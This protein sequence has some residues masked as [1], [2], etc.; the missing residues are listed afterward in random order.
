MKEDYQQKVW[1]VIASL[2][3][4]AVASGCI[5]E[6]TT[7]SELIRPT[8]GAVLEPD[9]ETGLANV[10]FEAVFMPYSEGAVVNPGMIHVIIHDAEE[11]LGYSEQTIYGGGHNP[12]GF[13]LEGPD[14]QGVYRLTGTMDL[15]PGPYG[16]RTS[17]A[18]PTGLSD[19]YS[20]GSDVALFLVM[21]RFEPADFVGS[22]Q[23]F[24]TELTAGKCFWLSAHPLLQGLFPGFLEGIVANTMLGLEMTVPGWADLPGAMTVWEE[25]PPM[26][27]VT[28]NLFVQEGKIRVTVTPDTYDIEIPDPADWMEMPISMNGRTYYICGF[29]FSLGKGT[30]YPVEPDL[31]HMMHHFHDMAFRVAAD[32]GSACELRRVS[33]WTEWAT[34][35]DAMDSCECWAYYTAF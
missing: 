4:I 10:A 13:T 19:Y 15:V 7:T 27:E 24:S 25:F 21:S 3:F 18:D 33:S 31:T 6:S 30:L 1:F 14:A 29:Q 35:L 26:P 9:A 11:I 5:S 17:C 23:N 34:P 32:P 2:L 12:H 28:A 8:A 20:D 22:V 16:I